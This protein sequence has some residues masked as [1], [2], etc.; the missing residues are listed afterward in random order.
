MISPGSE[1]QIPIEYRNRSFAI[2]AHVR[3]VS[4]MMPSTTVAIG[5]NAE[6]VVKTI[7]YAEGEIENAAMDVWE[8]TADGT[9]FLKSLTTNYVDPSRVWPFW[10]Y[11]TT[12][13]RK[14]QK[15]KPWKVV[16]LSRKMSDLRHPFGMIDQFLLT[17]GF[18]DE[19]ETLTMPGVET[20]TL[21]DLGLVVVDEAGDVIFGQDEFEVAGLRDEM[22]A[23]AYEPS[24]GSQVPAVLP[25]E[26]FMHDAAE[27]K[28]GEEIEA[29]PEV[30]EESQFMKNWW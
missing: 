16:E 27:V 30:V 14:Y 25:P 17:I 15:G 20:Q 19:C 3:Q 18:E 8:M 24:R 9:P 23:A 26:D 29:V 10:S 6:Q 22:P 11:R 21:L 4:D 28:A 13:I 1:I 5:D 2:K 7:V 12:L